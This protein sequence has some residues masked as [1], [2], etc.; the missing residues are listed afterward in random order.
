MATLGLTFLGTTKLFSPLWF[1]MHGGCSCRGEGPREPQDAQTGDLWL[2]SQSAV[3]FGPSQPWGAG[4]SHGC[5]S[6]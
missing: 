3:A 2:R 4:C 1:L 6:L 5:L